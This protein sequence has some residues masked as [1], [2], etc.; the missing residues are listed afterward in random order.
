MAPAGRNSDEARGG[1]VQPAV[2]TGRPN[3]GTVQPGS[4][5]DEHAGRA[6]GV[7]AGRPGSATVGEAAAADKR[8]GGPEPV[9]HA[10][11]LLVAGWALYGLSWLTP[12]ID[13]RQFGA[14][15]FVESARFAWNL[16]TTDNIVLGLCVL[17]G[18]LA[19]FA[20]WPRRL[21]GWLRIAA[22][23]APWLALAVVLLKLPVR[24]SLLGRALYF[25]YFYPW[26]VGIALIQAA[27]ISA[28]RHSARKSAATS[29]AQ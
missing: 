10:R 12:S 3:S 6:P 8:N 28:G 1:A 26:A 9:G 11:W 7:D 23:I 19:N 15:A 16:L 17:A 5:T 25:L 20:T 27:N 29:A 2:G 24:P 18:W 13:G 14:V 21:P 4:G 22:C